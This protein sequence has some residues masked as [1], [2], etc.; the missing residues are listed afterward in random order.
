MPGSTTPSVFSDTPNRFYVTRV[1]QQVGRALHD[2][3]VLGVISVLRYSD[4]IALQHSPKRSP[5]SPLKSCG[6]PWSRM[7]DIEH[8]ISPYVY[9]FLN[10]VVW[11]LHYAGTMSNARL[12]I[13]ASHLIIKAM[14]TAIVLQKTSPVPYSLLVLDIFGSSCIYYCKW[15][16][17]GDRTEP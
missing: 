10:L 2:R 6:W 17:G 7:P 12:G 11:A 13:Y 8:H 3:S 5:E 9:V 16:G 1:G 15:H 4:S 14:P